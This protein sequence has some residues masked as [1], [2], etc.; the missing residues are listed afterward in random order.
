[1]K[2]SS[3]LKRETH[4]D[5]GWVEERIYTLV[6]SYEGCTLYSGLPK[7]KR[8]IGFFVTCY[9]WFFFISH[10]LLQGRR[11]WYFPL[12]FVIFLFRDNFFNF[13]FCMKNHLIFHFGR[14]GWFGPAHLP[15]RWQENYL[16]GL[17]AA[18]SF[19]E[20]WKYI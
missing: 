6:F 8:L 18:L 20:R 16:S 7:F 15:A 2:N 13:W 10:I 17:G 11:I 4:T 14:V 5:G 1:M 9:C 12:I 19:L 3:G